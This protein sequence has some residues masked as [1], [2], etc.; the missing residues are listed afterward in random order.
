MT[1]YKR[2]QWTGIYAPLEAQ[3]ADIWITANM[4]NSSNWTSGPGNFDDFSVRISKVYILA[5][6]WLVAIF[7]VQLVLVLAYYYLRCGRRDETAMNQ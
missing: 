4:P 2:Q 3:M 5:R 6:R 1:K 7:I